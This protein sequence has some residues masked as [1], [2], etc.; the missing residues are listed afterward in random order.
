[1]NW[2][3]RQKSKRKKFKYFFSLYNVLLNNI[4]AAAAAAKSLQSCLTLCDPIEGSPPGSSV[5]GILQA[6]TLEWAAIS[7][8]NAWKWK[9]KVKTLSRVWLLSTPWIA[10]YQ[11]PPSMGFSRPRVLAGQ[12]IQ[13][14][15]PLSWTLANYCWKMLFA[16][17]CFC[18][19]SWSFIM[20]FHVQ[21]KNCTFK[22]LKYQMQ[23]HNSFLFSLIF[24]LLTFQQI[25]LFI[26]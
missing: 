12:N 6:R 14:L 4:F 20:F 21:A 11:A 25:P 17:Y 1:M 24:K 8:S 2:C 15:L 5:P 18:H 7:S 13:S 16:S 3:V 9:V 26:N 19:N 22:I 10:A 23:L